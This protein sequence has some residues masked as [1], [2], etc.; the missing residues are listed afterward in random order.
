MYMYVYICIYVIK[1]LYIFLFSLNIDC[2]FMFYLPNTDTNNNIEVLN[3]KDPHKLY[4]IPDGKRVV[5]EFNGMWQPVGKSG[6]KWRR[7]T[8]K[9]VRRGTFI[10]ISDDWKKVPLEQKE[11][12]FDAL[13]VSVKK[14]ILI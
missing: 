14:L 5:V 4:S 3:V 8:G 13:M 1:Y 9:M 11:L 6:G 2:K 7:M 12:F 10:R